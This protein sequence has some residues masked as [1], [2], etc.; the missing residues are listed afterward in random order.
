MKKL[1][2]NVLPAF[3]IAIVLFNCGGGPKF[4]EV[5]ELETYKDPATKFEVKYP[6]NWFVA[7]K[8]TGDRF[9]V[10]STKPAMERFRRYAPEGL[11]AVKIELNVTRLDSIITLDTVQAKNMIFQ[12][13]VYS[14]PEMVEINGVQVRK[15]D[16]AFELEDGPFH[17]VMYVGAKDT[18]RATVL[19]IEAFAG[20]WEHYKKTFDEI[21]SSLVLAQTPPKR[22]DT[23]Y[24]QQEAEPPS[25]ELKEKMGKGFSIKIPDNFNKEGGLYIG[26]RRGDSYIKVDVKDVSENV[27][28]DKTVEESRK[29]FPGASAAKA[30]KLDGQKALMFSYKPSGSVDGEVYFTMKGGKLYQITLNWFKGEADDYKPI[31]RKCAKTF[32]FQ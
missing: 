11:P 18:G 13:E 30:M 16:Y 5:K 28:F 3:L 24:V 22:A 2:L 26:G 20:S 8:L 23:V 10:Y 19:Q 17:G 14:E 7:Q 21:V 4:T 1:L 6:S 29:R 31:F 9:L 27:N 32:K 15:I 12:K 25:K